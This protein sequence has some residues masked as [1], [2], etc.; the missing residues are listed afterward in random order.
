[1][2]PP[3]PQFVTSGVRRIGGLESPTAK[4]DGIDER[5]DIDVAVLDGGVQPDHPDL[6]VVGGVDCVGTQERVGRP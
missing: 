1:M 4:I 6:N 2:P 5:I 3:P